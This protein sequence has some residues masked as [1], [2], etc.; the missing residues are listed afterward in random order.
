MEI[1]IERGKTV[2]LKDLP[3]Y[4]IALDGMVQGPEFDEENHRYSFDHHAGCSRFSTLSSCEQAWTAIM[5]G[6]DPEPY[7]IYCNDV[8]SDVCAAVWCLKNPDR[9]KEPLVAKLIDAIG[10]ADRYAGAFEINGMKK[11]V[12]WVCSPETDSK[13]NGDYEKLSNEGLKPILE[14]ILHRIDLYVDGG[15]SIEVAKQPQHGE[16]KVLRNENGWA[17]IETN[18]PHA[19]GAIWQAGFNKVVIL[20]PLEDKSTAVTL[21]KKSDFIDGFP[22]PKIYKAFNEIEPGW[23][24]SSTIGG[25]VRNADGS[26]SKLKPTQISKVIDDILA[27]KESSQPKKTTKKRSVKK[28]STTSSGKQA[29]QG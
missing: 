8:D 13:R 21:A 2:K 18:D 14:S 7:T 1:I 6:L 3:E 24:G 15:S 26:R 29:S 9:C 22:L 16:F 17:L 23:G 4:S 19:L 28:K 12:E 10:K 27:G 20:R 11:I 25:C 5:L